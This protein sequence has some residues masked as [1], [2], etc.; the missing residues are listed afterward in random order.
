MSI[1]VLLYMDSKQ[2]LVEVKESV[3][4]NPEVSP[5]GSV[6]E[7]PVGVSSAVDLNSNHYYARHHRL[8]S[9]NHPTNN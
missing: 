9:N 7:L 1:Y 6:L 3:I 5:C 8:T 4:G 2:L